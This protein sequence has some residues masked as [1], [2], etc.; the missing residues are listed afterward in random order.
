MRGLAVPAALVL[1]SALAAATAPQP[2]FLATLTGPTLLLVGSPGDLGGASARFQAL[3]DTD[4]MLDLK[5]RGRTVA[6]GDPGGSGLGG[7][8]RARFGLDATGP[9][10]GLILGGQVLLS[11]RQLPEPEALAQALAR[12]GIPNPAARLEVFLKD[13][14]EHAE[15]RRDL[16]QALRPR[17][18]ARL[19][20]GLADGPEFGPA[21]DARIW[22]AMAQELDRL[23]QG[24]DWIGLRLNLDWGLFPEG[25]PERRSPLMKALYRR[26][27]PRVLAGLRRCPVSAANAVA[28][29]NLL[30]MDAVLGDQE[31][32]PFL[33]GL[34]WYQTTPVEAAML[35]YQRIAQG[36]LAEARRTGAWSRAAGVLRTLW[37]QMA[38]PKL[39]YLGKGMLSAAPF[40]AERQAELSRRE[41]EEVWAQLLEPL[42]EALVRADMAAEVTALLGELDQSW[43]GVPLE[44][45]LRRLAHATGQPGLAGAWVAAIR[46]LPPQI[47]G[48]GNAGRGLV[49]VH[50]DQKAL[51]PAE[52]ERCAQPFWDLGMDVALKEATESWLRFLGWAGS[53]P[54]W[55][56]VD[57]QG[58]ILLQGEALPR[59]GDLVAV[60]QRLGLPS[61]RERV[62]A[63]LQDHPDHL[64]AL[65][66]A[67][68]VQQA[69]AMA[70]ARVRIEKRSPWD[71]L[72]EMGTEERAAW[73]NYFECLERLLD[74][75]LSLCPGPLRA[76]S[77]F[78]SPA[79]LGKEGASLGTE[80]ARRCLP[81]VEA[82]LARRPSDRELWQ[83]WLLLAPHLERRLTD[84]LYTLAP[85]PLVPL[86]AWPPRD[87]LARAAEELRHQNRW[88]DLVDLLQPR[89]KAAAARV[90]QLRRIGDPEVE[91]GCHTWA[92]NETRPLL[93]AYL[94]L[95]KGREADAILDGMA[96]SDSPP[97][98]YEMASLARIA[99]E[100]GDASW[101]RKWGQNPPSPA[102]RNDS[103]DRGGSSGGG[104]DWLPRKP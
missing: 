59:G 11:G 37:W 54:R 28:W 87:L 99:E 5:V 71:G 64:G 92:W 35:P 84:V 95:G 38:R 76:A 53:S 81:R 13:R 17:L 25:L 6:E 90:E 89:R 1:A 33:E 7:W 80:V 9:A 73:Q 15:A 49:V 12:A 39:T 88:Q 36:V 48:E 50:Q 104:A 45:R 60:Y 41:R 77:G 8:L 102:P 72:P 22:G 55:A 16:I 100:Q 27:R 42:I 47:P 91:A 96:A 97:N 103:S 14:P 32:L 75:P 67:L 61:E 62:A 56:L 18:F 24:E 30:H 58:R 20:P 94:R 4:A 78:P 46:A 65:A 19:G 93:E 63:F 40:E 29:N 10:W 2:A 31:L 83:F 23:F 34:S 85:S 79:L 98:P 70:R 66:H 51:G 69:I 82:A 52:Q 3:L 68:T 44:G 43:A 21:E 26:H 74:D 101:A 57:V 86:E